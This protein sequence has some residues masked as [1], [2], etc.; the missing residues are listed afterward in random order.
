M[1]IIFLLLFIVIIAI[2]VVLGKLIV[3]FKSYEETTKA[4]VEIFMWFRKRHEH[5]DEVFHND[6]DILAFYAD[7]QNLELKDRIMAELEFPIIDDDCLDYRE[8][9]ITAIVCYQKLYAK[10]MTILKEHP[11][12]NRLLALEELVDLSDLDF[13]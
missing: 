5:L 13:S 2:L 7:N 11:L 3:L 12:L 4:F 9:A 10:Y 1:Y 6:L 8:K